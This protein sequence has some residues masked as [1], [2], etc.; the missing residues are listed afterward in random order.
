MPETLA[1]EDQIRDLTAALR[2]VLETCDALQEDTLLSPVWN[3]AETVRAVVVAN[4][5]PDWTAN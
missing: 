5:G 2:A 4:V 3:A 1:P